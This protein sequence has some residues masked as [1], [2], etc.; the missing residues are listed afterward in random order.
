MINCLYTGQ[1]VTSQYTRIRVSK[2][3][4]LIISA[5]EGQ[6]S[7]TAWANISQRRPRNLQAVKPNWYNF[8]VHGDVYFVEIY[9]LFAELLAKYAHTEEDELTVLRWH[10]SPFYCSFKETKEIVALLHLDC[11]THKPFS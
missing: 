7:Y 6:I 9:Q 11:R 3:S 2:H 4:T 8:T 5:D 10:H 1:S